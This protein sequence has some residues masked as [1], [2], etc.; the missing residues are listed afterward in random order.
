VLLRD[1]DASPGRPIGAIV[2]EI[3]LLAAVGL[4]SPA[5]AAAWI[6]SDLLLADMVRGQPEIRGEAW[7]HSPLGQRWSSIGGFM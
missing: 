5:V 6:G 2:T 1:S 7:W 3:W 4:G